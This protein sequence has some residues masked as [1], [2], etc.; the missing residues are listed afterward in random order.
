[1]IVS[2]DILS[3][4]NEGLTALWEGHTQTKH[5][6]RE[7]HAP[8][9]TL[10]THPCVG[11]TA[12]HSSPLCMSRDLSWKKNPDEEG[13]EVLP[14]LLLGWTIGIRNTGVASCPNRSEKSWGCSLAKLYNCH[15]ECLCSSWEL[16]VLPTVL[17]CWSYNEAFQVSRCL[18]ISLS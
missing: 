16:S 9:C 14:C 3:L 4:R 8:K 15:P 1:M 12:A 13:I 10:H 11:H 17:K 7:T 18:P 2:R 6:L 5:S